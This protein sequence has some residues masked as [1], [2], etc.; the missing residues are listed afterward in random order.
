MLANLSSCIAKTLINFFV[1]N[2]R[3]HILL[4]QN[5]LTFILKRTLNDCAEINILKLLLKQFFVIFHYLPKSNNNLKKN[6]L[7][8][9]FISDVPNQQ[10]DCK[11]QCYLNLSLNRMRGVH[12]YLTSRVAKVFNRNL[13][14]ELIQ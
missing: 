14:L 3:S 1:T 4:L 12:N 6:M 11:R 10:I 5:I 8:K 2:N 9:V 7:Q 13:S